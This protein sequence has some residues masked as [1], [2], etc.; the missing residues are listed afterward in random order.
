MTFLLRTVT[1]LALTVFSAPAQDLTG[2]IEKAPSIGII[3]VK[4]LEAAPSFSS[5]VQVTV[6]NKTDPSPSKAA[7]RFEYSKGNIR[8]EGN[9]ADITSSQLSVQARE[10]LRQ[11]N[12]DRF[13]LLTRSDKN[14]NYL[15]LARAQAC[16]EDQ[17]PAVK[18]V[19]QNSTAKESIDGRVCRKE[20][21]SARLPDGTAWQVAVWKASDAKGVP[22]QIQV[23]DNSET[24]TIRFQDVQFRPVDIARFQVPGGL[25][26][27][28]SVEDLIQSVLLDRL[29]RRMG[30]ER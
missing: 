11:I 8:W 25:S 16:L 13:L 15:I 14:L 29:K 3:L 17:L 12:G 6:T 10:A 2:L 23:V 18:V 28:S 21:I 20:K 22:L 30:I 27:Y 26:V 7:A 5:T 4:V 1:F 24:F 19:L 9:L